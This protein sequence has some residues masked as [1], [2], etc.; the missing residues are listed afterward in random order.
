MYCF[1]VC[2]NSLNL[3]DKDNSSTFEYPPPVFRETD[4]AIISQNLHSKKW[5]RL[6][7]RQNYVIKCLVYPYQINLHG[8]KMPPE[9]DRPFLLAQ[10]IRPKLS[11]CLACGKKSTGEEEEFYDTST[12][13]EL[14]ENKSMEQLEKFKVY[15]T[16]AMQLHLETCLKNAFCKFRSEKSNGAKETAGAKRVCYGCKKAF[17]SHE[18]WL[19]H[20]QERTCI[21]EY[22]EDLLPKNKCKRKRDEL[23]EGFSVLSL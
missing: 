6:P 19:E 9:C 4:S 23:K 17:E 3:I 13:Y 12:K 7:G 20:C 8:A 10:C 14:L 21:R 18:V 16:N 15:G 22:L 1:L 11:V 2:L 5:F